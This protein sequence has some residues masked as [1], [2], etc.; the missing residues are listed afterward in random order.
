[1]KCIRNNLKKCVAAFF[2]ILVSYQSAFAEPVWHCSRSD[3]QIADASDDFTLASLALER[4]VI[5]I[6]L[7]DLFSV[8]QGSP[9]KMTGSLP[10][11]ACVISDDSHLSVTALQSIGIQLAM[12]KAIS[13]P[14]A[15]LK[16][17]VY[18]IRDEAEMQTCIAK[19][20]PA[21]GYL[22]KATQTEAVGP[23]F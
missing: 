3:V 9:V 13:S 2:S 10:L 18:T 19:H 4:E 5:R 21:V 11:S 6:S 12:I 22:S 8:Y 15:I 14:H 20:H 7:R 23:C 17:H 16:S 1:M